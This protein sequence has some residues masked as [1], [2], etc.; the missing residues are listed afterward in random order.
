MS[1]LPALAQER[2]ITAEKWSTLKGVLYPEASDKMIALAVD[3]C[4]SKGWDVMAKPVYIIGFGGKEQ[5]V[6][7]IAQ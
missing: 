6:P 1:N 2:N 3:Y 4:K 7:S 5:I